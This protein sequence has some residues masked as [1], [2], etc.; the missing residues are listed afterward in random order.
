MVHEMQRPMNTPEK[1][2][3]QYSSTAIATTDPNPVHDGVMFLRDR[4]VYLDWST[5]PVNEPVRYLGPD[6]LVEVSQPMPTNPNP[7]YQAAAPIFFR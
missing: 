4:P 2:D 5:V 1:S 6:G 3:F 7:V